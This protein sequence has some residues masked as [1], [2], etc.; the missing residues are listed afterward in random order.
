LRALAT[1]WG[2]YLLLRGVFNR[3]EKVKLLNQDFSFYLLGGG[4][5][6]D[7]ESLELVRSARALLK[8]RESDQNHTFL[9]LL[10]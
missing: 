5:S 3:R 1:K 7:F 4:N 8:E 10:V 9:S 2:Y 6:N